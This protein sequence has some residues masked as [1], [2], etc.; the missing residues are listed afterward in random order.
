MESA[1]SHPVPGYTPEDAKDVYNALEKIMDDV[2]TRYGAER[3]SSKIIVGMSLGGLHSLFISSIEKNRPTIGFDRYI[4]INPPV[5]MA[6]A[7]ERIDRLMNIWRLWGE[8]EL[9]NNVIQAGAFYSELL[10]GGFDDRDSSPVDR[11]S[12]EFLIGLNFQI[13]LRNMIYSIHGRTDYGFINVPSNWFSRDDLY[14]QIDM[15]DFEAYY[16]VFLRKCY[17]RSFEGK[18]FSSL[19]FE[20]GIFSIANELDSN[21]RVRVLHN[22][23]DFLLRKQDI[24]WIF[25]T[26]GEKAVVFNTGG[27][28]GNLFMKKV[29]DTI[30]S[31]VERKAFK[32]FYEESDPR[33]SG[34]FYSGVFDCGYDGF[35]INDGFRDY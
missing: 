34:L 11:E 9:D 16:K 7:V 23:N 30:H 27:H 6:Y 8:K 32:G 20:S 5:N 15:Y 17:E 10:N 19:S 33:A 2:E 21:P 22:A 31:L 24:K 29:Q 13:V 26:F 18:P 12:A 1:G 35:F 28:L 14:R 25:D 4:A 3:I